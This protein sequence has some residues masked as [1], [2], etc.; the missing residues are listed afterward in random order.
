MNHGKSRGKTVAT[1]LPGGALVFYC[2]YRVWVRALCTTIVVCTA[3]AGRP[4][5]N[6]SRA[7]HRSGIY[8][9]YY[10]VPTQ[11]V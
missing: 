11:D 7:G 4:K 1:T 3:T 10:I 8:T 6:K 5:T 2:D 9:Y